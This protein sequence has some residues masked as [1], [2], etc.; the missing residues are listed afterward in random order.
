M[1]DLTLYELQISY[2]GSGPAIQ[3]ARGKD[4]LR[5]LVR[6]NLIS[7]LEVEEGDEDDVEELTPEDIDD[8]AYIEFR[9]EDGWIEYRVKAAEMAAT[10][11]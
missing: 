11:A 1:T 2:F 7:D 5:K 10:A 9:L 6:W 8:G 3:H 4:E